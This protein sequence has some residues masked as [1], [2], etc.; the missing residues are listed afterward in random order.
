MRAA[1]MSL[2]YTFLRA[3]LLAPRFGP[4]LR[5][6]RYPLA[7]FVIAAILGSGLPV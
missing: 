3:D 2:F 7:L 5:P 6:H 1:H 4:G